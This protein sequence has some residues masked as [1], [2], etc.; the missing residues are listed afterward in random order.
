MRFHPPHDGSVNLKTAVADRI[1]AEMI[2]QGVSGRELARRVGVDQKWVQRR[3]T[4]EIEVRPSDL[5]KIAD[6]LVVPVSRL[7]LE[8]KA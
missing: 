7:L 5:E 3:L 2:D 1:R 6:A 4:G 8:M